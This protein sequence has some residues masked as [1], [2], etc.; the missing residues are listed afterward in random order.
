MII[1]H[2]EDLLGIDSLA[3]KENF[4]FREWK[5]DLDVMEYCGCELQRTFKGGRHQGKYFDKVKS[6]AYDKKFPLH[7]L[8]NKREVT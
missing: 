5:E 2:V 4:S 7:Q 1:M 3:M 6:I 8:F